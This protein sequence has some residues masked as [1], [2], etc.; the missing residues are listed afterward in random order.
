MTDLLTQ[1]ASAVVSGV[2]HRDVRQEAVL[3]RLQRVLDDLKSEKRWRTLGWRRTIQGVYVYGSVGVGKTYLMD[4][5]FHSIPFKQKKRYHFHAFM[6]WIDAQLRAL[7]GT[8]NPLQQIAHDF[9]QTTRVLCL[10]EFLVHDVADALMLVE[11]LQVLFA[12]KVVLV[13]T[14]NTAIEQLYAGGVQRDRFLPAIAA[15]QQQCDPIFIAAVEDYRTGRHPCASAYLYPLNQASAHLLDLQ[16]HHHASSNIITDEA[17]TVQ[18]RP[19]VCVKQSERVVWFDFS[20]LCQIPRCQ[21][22]YLELATRFDT[23]CLSQVPAFS[24]QNTTALVLFILLIDVLYDQSV[25]LIMTAAV[26]IDQLYVEGPFLKSFQRTRSRLEEMQSVD[27][28][29]R[30][31]EVRQRI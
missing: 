22:D 25:E 13:A 7:Q 27:Y 29:T 26:P 2:L 21:L 8:R 10:D 12:K 24:A 5:F 3:Q 18:R 6:Q 19:L 9:A 30:V 16:F 17:L 11:L 1:Y 14:S 4:L 28:Q 23:V 31:R 15:L 20:V